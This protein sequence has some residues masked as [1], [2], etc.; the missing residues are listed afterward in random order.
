MSR[1]AIAGEALPNSIGYLSG[2]IS[3]PQ[4]LKPGN[5]MPPLTLSPAELTA[6]RSWLV[7]LQ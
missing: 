6:I 4:A 5:L 7:T 2:W 3:D 1:G